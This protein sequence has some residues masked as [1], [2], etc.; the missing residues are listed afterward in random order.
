M[1]QLLVKSL[2]AARKAFTWYPINAAN[3]EGFGWAYGGGVPE[4]LDIGDGSGSSLVEACVSW[5]ANQVTATNP[6]VRRRSRADPIGEIEWDHPAARLVLDPTFDAR[7]GMSSYSWIPMIQATITSIVVSGD[8]YWRKRRSKT[9]RVIQLWYQPYSSVTTHREDFSS[10]LVDYYEIRSGVRTT[11]VSPRDM[12]HFRDGLDPMDPTHGLSKL[13]ALFRELYTDEAAARWTER[14]LRNEAVPGLILSPDVGASPMSQEEARDVKARIDND[15][16]GE[17]R[18]RTMVFGA[19]TKVHQYSFSPDQMK[20][21]DLRDPPEERV[22]AALGVSA[23][24]V[25][26]GSGLQTAKVGATMG[27]LVDL[28]WQNGVFPRLRLLGAELTRQLLPDFENDPGL[29]FIF[30]TS[31]T[32]IMAEFQNKIAE[33]HERLMRSNIETRAEARRA[34]GLKAGKDDDV[35]TLQSGVKVM[36]PDGTPQV[37]PPKPVAAPAPQPA[38]PAGDAVAPAPAKMLTPRE[39][40]VAL[41]VALGRTNKLIAHELDIGERTVERDIQAALGKIDGES[42]VALGVYALKPFA[43]F[44]N[45]A[46]CVSSM[47]DD[48]K[49]EEA[50]HRICGALQSQEE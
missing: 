10:Y 41:L 12:I 23:A 44:D 35:Y 14:L 19:P 33:K 7:T 42:R 31:E 3:I 39:R 30:D 40:K 24:V 34:V 16:T 9:D 29:S 4:T 20:I 27:E 43:G 6:S 1:S 15:F 49:D 18:G 2:Q 48:G 5:I 26:F 17:N 32:P 11:R 37:E 21:A 46:A 22:S 8:A 47:M 45:F 25:G 38:L 36:N 13:R 28:S 50:A